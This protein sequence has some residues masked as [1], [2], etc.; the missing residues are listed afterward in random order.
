MSIEL[1]RIDDRLIH[2]L[3]VIGWA[4]AIRCHQ[5]IVANDKVALNNLQKTLM[6]A[7]TPEGIEVSI[8]SI[9]EAAD[10][11]KEGKCEAISTM[12]LI[13]NPKDALRLVQEGVNIKSINLG[14]MHFTPDRKQV[15]SSISMTE[16]EIE[17]C[18]QLANAGIE[19]EVRIS[20][21]DCKVNLFEHIKKGN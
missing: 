12:L 14:G 2:G 21:N 1:C 11:I 19:I 15:F 3:V 18:Q 8:V 13:S 7:A 9:K 17:I 4:P 20:P 5:I 16:E 6:K 10:L